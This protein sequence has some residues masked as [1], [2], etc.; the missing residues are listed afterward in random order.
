M[1]AAEAAQA[2]EW[3]E[4]IGAIARAAGS[5]I[6][7]VYESGSFDATRKQ[8][9]SPLTA[10][11]LR[12]HRSIVAALAR[13]TPDIPVF[14][15][16]AAAIPWA[17]R[18]RWRRY[19]LVDPLD[20][21]KEF[22]SRN[23]QFT[24]NIALIE[25]HAPALGVVHVPVGGLSYL[26]VPG[27]GAWREQPGEPRRQIRVRSRCANPPQVVG[28]RSHRGDSLDAFLA[29]L[30]AHELKPMGSSLKFCLI[31]EGSADVYPRL[32]PTC[33]WDTAAAQAVVVAAGG[34]VLQLDGEALRYNTR[35]QVLNP[36]FVAFGPAAPAWL[37]LLDAAGQGG[38]GS[39][40]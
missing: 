36:F 28:S 10:A 37:E 24:V 27:Q 19:W 18:A 22:I 39:H 32:G 2:R 17:E 13:L 9:D 14:S 4:A 26:G 31:A 20:G 34:R 23:G 25:D 15:E 1:T 6:L 21:T 3:L 7:Q 5:E 11:D 35:E 29:R 40:R 12:A 33:E 38:G 30:G 8:D 16:E